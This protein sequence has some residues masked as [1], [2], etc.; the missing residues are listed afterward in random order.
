MKKHLLVSLLIISIIS[1]SRTFGQDD[2]IHPNIIK[3]PI[4]FEI[5]KPLRDN[6]I[7]EDKVLSDE[8]F[9]MNAQRDRE[10]NPNIFPPDFDIMPADPGIQ[11]KP[12]WIEGT[13]AT[14]QNFAGQNSSSYPPDC[15]GDANATYFFQVVNTTYA[16]YNK[17]TGTIVAGPSA[18]NSIFNSSLPGASC[19]S[20]D[21]IVLWDQQAE[22]WFYAE[23]S[24]C[25]FK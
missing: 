19:N 9:Y 23:F 4:A 24:L 18:L 11:T 16:I 21:P 3:T 1:M 17:T 8:E 10:I 5:T 12:G 22:R 20:G 13:K 7:V 6:P 14:L 2:P 25:G 15:S